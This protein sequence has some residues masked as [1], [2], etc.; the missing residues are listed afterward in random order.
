MADAGYMLQED[1]TM[2]MH[3]LENYRSGYAPVSSNCMHCLVRLQLACT[4]DEALAEA[5][6][7]V[8]VMLSLAAMHGLGPAD[9]QQHDAAQI[10]Q[11]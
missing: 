5:F 11:C 4:E 1:V 10:L 2:T 3:S 8:A 9:R 7:C 6:E